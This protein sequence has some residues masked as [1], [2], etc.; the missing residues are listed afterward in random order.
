MRWFFDVPKVKESTFFK[1]DLTD[2]PQIFDAHLLEK[3]DLSPSRFYFSVG[4]IYQD[5]VLSRMVLLFIR[6]KKYLFFAK[7][8]MSQR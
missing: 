7:L 8:A 3:T 6:T 1:S 2:P 5:H 4:L